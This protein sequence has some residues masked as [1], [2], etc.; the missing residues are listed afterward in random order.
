MAYYKNRRE[1]PA[2]RNGALFLRGQDD[3][4]ILPDDLA[5]EVMNMVATDDGTLRT[6]HGPIPYVPTKTT[7]ISGPGVVLSSVGTRPRSAVSFQ[8]S[9]VRAAVTELASCDPTIP[10]YG[11]RQHG[12]F[13]A[14][15][16]NGERDILL[17]HT[18]GELWEFRGWNRN[19][20]RLLSNPAGSHGLQD[21]LH[22][23]DAARFPTQFETVGNGIVI[24]PQDGRAYFYDGHLLCPLGFTEKPT[25]PIGLGP[26]STAMGNRTSDNIAG[27][28]DTDYAHSGLYAAKE[29][30]TK[31]GMTYGF[32]KCRIGSVNPYLTD[33]EGAKFEAG[34]LDGGEWRCKVVFIDKFG[35]LS[36][37][38]EAS[39]PI[40]FDRQGAEAAPGD[41]PTGEGGSGANDFRD[42]VPWANETSR[43]AVAPE[44]LKMQVAWTGIAEGPDHCVGRILYRTKDLLNSGEGKYFELP[45]DTSAVTTGFATLPD[46]VTTIYPDNMSDAFLGLPVD[47]II[48]VP[49]FKLCRVA[50]G[51][52]FVANTATNEG[53]I[54]F[55]QPGRWGTFRQDDTVYPDPRGGEITGL[56][57]CDQGLLAFTTS[58]TFLITANSTGSDFTASP[59]SQQVGCSAPNSIQTLPDGRVMWLSKDGFFSFDGQSVNFESENLKRTFK[60][61]THSR[62]RQACS[63]YDTYSKEYRCWVSVDGSKENNFCLTYTGKSWRTRADIAPRDVCVTQDHRNYMLAAGSVIGDNGRHDGVYLLDHAASP[64]PSERIVPLRNITDSRLAFIETVW[65]QG[66]Q[67]KLKETVPVV[68]LWF[69]ET[70]GSRVDIEVMRDWREDVVEVAQIERFTNV[71]PP[72]FLG[73]AV[74]GSQSDRFRRRRPY[75]TRAQIYL[76]SAESFKLRIRGTGFWEFVGLSFDTAQRTYGNAQLPG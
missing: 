8:D 65:M 47:N 33:V 60:R 34:L 54:H 25:A 58:S 32:G 30:Y 52:L 57:R 39:E 42:D 53:A 76:P 16:Q 4:L 31:S 43:T 61:L 41:T 44:F 62:F 40:T 51:R 2:G 37:P 12:I 66:A 75:W 73:Q 56:W 55:S 67:S 5:Q 10:V 48:P 50:F 11:R 63:A 68:Y 19:W 36:A 13:H 35:N 59:V 28:N 20:R 69:R 70:A 64:G 1:V 6:V 14:L 29:E 7:L 15:L 24:V 18:G 49:Q 17:L 45:L 74:L 38:S 21:R 72:S 26:S 9:E 23:D 71:D 27:V 3:G 22:D 46:N